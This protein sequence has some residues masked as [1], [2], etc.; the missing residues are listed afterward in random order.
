MPAQHDESSVLRRRVAELEAELQAQRASN[1]ALRESEE[2]HRITLESISDAVF[3]TNDEGALTFICPNVEKIFGYSYEDVGTFA[4]ISTLLGEGLV[5]ASRL[6]AQRE[7]RNIERHIVDRR[8]Q[9]HDLIVNVKCV[10]IQDGTRLYTC[11][12]ITDRKEVEDALRQSELQL[13]EAQKIAGMGFWDWNI[14]SNDLYWSEEIYRIFGL[15]NAEFGATFEAFLASVHPDDRASVQGRVS[16]AVEDDHEYS[17]DHRIVRP[18]GEM[19]YVHEL[20]SVM[21]D[22]NG[23]PLRMVGTVIDITARTL[24]NEARKTAEE[25]ARHAEELA[26]LGTLLAG[27]AHDVG[28]PVNVILGYAQMMQRSLPEGKDRERSRVIAEQAKRVASLIQTLM[29]V[30]HPS[31]RIHVPVNIESCLDA[32]LDFVNEKLAR[33]GIEVVRRMDPSLEVRGDPDRL[34]QAFLNLF[35]NAADAM[36]QGGEL[37]VSASPSRAAHVEISV[38]DSG[39]G[40]PA[41]NL[42]RIFDPFFTT[43]PRGEGT[44]LGLLVTRRIVLEHGGTIDATSEVGTGTCFRIQLPSLVANGS[45]GD[46][47]PTERG[48][49]PRNGA[50]G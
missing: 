39:V 35:I 18:N 2:L 33:R 28:T 41:E 47:D 31:E 38:R 6:D 20:G 22:E 43:K 9:G 36:P 17:I 49:E 46:S 48:T 29:N 4:N 34:Q 42:A 44:G 7:I 25:R 37:E 3:V 24:A 23:K 14:V 40:I 50:A 26:A 12:D 19:R 10:D 16:A 45:K 1:S 21:R 27:L 8:G 11:R 32:A 13:R 5:D 15:G 30:A